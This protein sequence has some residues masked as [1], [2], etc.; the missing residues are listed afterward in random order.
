MDNLSEAMTYSSAND[1]IHHTIMG[2]DYSIVSLSNK[3]SI[4]G[5]VGC[6]P[7][8]G[9]NEGLQ[10]RSFSITSVFPGTDLCDFK[11]RTW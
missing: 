9:V 3:F 4:P 8:G 10:G 5:H 7:F 6:F 11:E 1:F 2:G